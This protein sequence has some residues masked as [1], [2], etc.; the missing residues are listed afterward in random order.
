MPGAAPISCLLVKV[1]SRCNLAC[2]YCY[3]YEHADQSWRDQPPVMSAAVVH[4]LGEQVARYVAASHQSRV[5]IVFHGG[6]PLLAG[7]PRLASFASTLRDCVGSACQLD[8]SLQTNGVLLTRTVLDQLAAAD[9]AVSLSLDGPPSVND[10]HRLR[11]TGGSSFAATMSALQLLAERPAQFT[12]VIAVIDADTPPDQLLG[13]FEPLRL[14][15]LDF[16]LPDANHVRPP[17]GRAEDPDRYVRWL[18]NAFDLWFDKYSHVPLRTFDAVLAATAGRPSGTD[19]FGF[20]DVSL[21]TI[22]TDGSYHD[23]DVLKITTHG[24]TALHGSVF[25]TS[26]EEVA[27]SPRLAIHRAMLRVDGVSQVCQACHEVDV[28]GGGAVP[29]RFDVDGFDHPSVYCRELLSLI[30]HARERLR[31]ELVDAAINRP[32]ALAKALPAGADR[33]SASE[34]NAMLDVWRAD[35]SSQLAELATTQAEHEVLNGL[36]PGDLSALAISPQAHLWRTLR[37]AELDGVVLKSI[38]GARLTAPAEWL[39]ACAPTLAEQTEWP[40]IHRSDAML[41]QAFDG[42]IEF[43]DSD[44][45]SAAEPLILEAIALVRDYDPVLVDEMRAISPEIQLI[46]DRS[47]DPDKVVS[48][49]D[50]VVP[51]ALYIAP[52]R[53]DG[54]LIDVR[55]VAD[56]LVHEHRHQKLYLVNRLVSLVDQ[57]WPEVSSPWRDDP[58]PPSGLL[59]A[60]YVFVELTS[61]WRWLERSGAG[62]DRARARQTHE[63]IDGQLADA[64]PTLRRCRLSDAGFQMLELL[65]RRLT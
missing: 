51:G 47:A 39:P 28:C 19:A 58:R 30:S 13:F 10:R 34:L 43:L 60:A 44:E 21:L 20:G 57:D 55:D 12:G 26:I 48:F 16:L 33:A 38:G 29:H 45:A 42:P 6:E 15:R 35:A 32:D 65:E 5:S 27:R 18:I 2:D 14:P 62:P 54:P 22:E 50:D 24:G 23:L 61:F 1:A 31:L 36:P 63:R 59:H 46:R 17:V 53:G 37:Q 56:S 8:F 9:I 52:Y 41:R 3:V 4:A 40:R 64:M 25:D 49:S 7:A 11:R